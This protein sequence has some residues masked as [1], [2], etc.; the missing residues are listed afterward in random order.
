MKA[1]RL[2]SLS[3]LLLPCLA[4]SCVGG[5]TLGEHRRE[6]SQQ[7]NHYFEA[8]MRCDMEYEQA[9]AEANLVFASNDM[10]R[11]RYLAAREHMLITRRYVDL[12]RASLDGRDECFSDRVMPP[13]PPCSPEN[14]EVDCDHPNCRNHPSCGPCGTSDTVDCAHP[15]CFDDPRCA[16]CTAYSGVID[17]A[18]P[19]CRGREECQPCTVDNPTIDCAHPNCAANPAC[20]PCTELNPTV[21]CTHPNCAAAPG[22]VRVTV[23]R[24]YVVVTETQIEINQQIN[25][26]TGSDRIVGRESFAVLD[27]VVSVLTQFPTMTLE[28][29]G[30]TDNVGRQAFNMQLSQ[31]RADSVRR[32]LIE[33]G[34]D[35]SRLR[36][37]GYGPDSPIEDNRTEE[38]RAANRRVEFHI[39]S[40]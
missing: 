16:P 35:A 40:R 28:V 4:W 22:C 38:G 31:R 5:M 19:N 2:S 13:P 11:G 32:Y 36:A 12:L 29:Q 33:A 7:V 26:A 30:H 10:E 24:R 39:L 34:I 18:H 20:A 23:E 15:L 21:D 25:F 9:S 1:R 17:C 8:A 6:L 14:L 37:R 3:L 27:D